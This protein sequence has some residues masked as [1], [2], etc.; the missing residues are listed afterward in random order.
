MLLTLC[1]LGAL[2]QGASLRVG[3]EAHDYYPY[4][5]AE[6]EGVPQGY[7]VAL[8]QAFAKY[9]ELDLEIR[10]QPINRLYHNLLNEQSLDLLFPD[11]PAWSRQ[12]KA[13]KT[14]HYS[15][16]AIQVVDGTL[17]LSERRGQGLAKIRRIG[18]VKG[19][20][21]QAWTTLLAKGQ[22]ELVEAQDIQS[23]IRM[24]EHGRLD[25]LYAN[26][27][28]VRH[29]LGEMGL[30]TGRLQLDQQLPLVYTSFH[31]SSPN[32]PELIQRFNRFLIEQHE[33]L[34]TLRQRY[35]LR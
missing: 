17:V 33:E 25:A 14:L 15:D 18:T 24:V 23:L 34:A 28:V 27:E 35:G 19:F 10:A 3:I 30:P 1:L 11:N 6:P 21:A 16:A 2:A 32:H 20:T 22:V 7:A 9:A 8:L 4:Y 13:D 29:Q 26:P 12:A 5:R 31:L